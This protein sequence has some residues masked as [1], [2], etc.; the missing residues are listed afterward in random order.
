MY[1]G[2]VVP[3]WSCYGFAFNDLERPVITW[4]EVLISY[5]NYLGGVSWTGNQGIQGVARA[6]VQSSIVPKGIRL[7]SSIST[8]PTQLTNNDNVL[9][10]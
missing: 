9:N 2:T 1:E 3:W 5:L 6:Q 4:V 7:L 10:R 8:Q